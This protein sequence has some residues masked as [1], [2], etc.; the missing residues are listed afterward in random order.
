M[1]LLIVAEASMRLRIAGNGNDR[2]R[3]AISKKTVI[4]G[5]NLEESSDRASLLIAHTVEPLDSGSQRK[6]ASAPGI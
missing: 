1:L 4:A 3:L 6:G 2:K 5:N